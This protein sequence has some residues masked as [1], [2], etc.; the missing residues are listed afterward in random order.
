MPSFKHNKKNHRVCLNYI[1]HNTYLGLFRQ[2]NES[3]PLDK[4]LYSPLKNS[5]FV[6]Y[7]GMRTHIWLVI[8]MVIFLDHSSF[9]ACAVKEFT[10][11][12]YRERKK[13]P[14]CKKS[15][16]SLA[17]VSYFG[18][19]HEKICRKQLHSLCT[20]SIHDYTHG[21]YRCFGHDIR[22][23]F[24]ISL[25]TQWRWNF[26]LHDNKLARISLL[27]ISSWCV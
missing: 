24:S 17:L 11:T 15:H 27:V 1:D 4:S 18:P 19:N 21:R 2:F 5:R 10:H 23:G 8:G 3:I 26:Y 16:I 20:V 13:S 9:H 6:F 7:Y 12:G 25:R 14:K 22:V